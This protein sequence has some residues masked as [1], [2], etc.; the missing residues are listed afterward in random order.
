MALTANQLSVNLLQPANPIYV[1]AVTTYRLEIKNTNNLLPSLES[2]GRMEILFPRQLDLLTDSCQ[3]QTST[4][5]MLNCDTVLASDK[6]TISSTGVNVTKNSIIQ[7]TFVN[8]VR[9]PVTTAVSDA[10]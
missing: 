5:I 2:G 6:I 4:N 10:F 8:N 7:V 1:G 9:N 3:A